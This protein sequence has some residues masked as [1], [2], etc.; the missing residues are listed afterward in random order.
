VDHSRSTLVRLLLM[1]GICNNIGALCC[2]TI[3][4][5]LETYSANSVEKGLKFMI[6]HMQGWSNV[7]GGLRRNFGVEPYFF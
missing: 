5:F 6:D 7:F 4:R 1:D 2:I 3:Y